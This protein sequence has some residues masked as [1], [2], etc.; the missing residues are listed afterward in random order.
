MKDA[1]IKI[2][3]AC[4]VEDE[5]YDVFYVEENEFTAE[6]F[7]Y[8][9]DRSRTDWFWIVDR[10][11]EFNGK[12]LYVPSEH[13]KEY[14]HVFKISGHLEFRY[15]KDFTD[16]WDFRCGGV[17]LVHKDFDYTKHKYQPKVIH[18]RYDI[19]YIDNPSNF[20]TILTIFTRLFN[21]ILMDFIWIFTIIEIRM[22]L[23]CPG[24]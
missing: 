19:F 3:P 11:F 9:A 13:E 2:H 24:H 15:P 14:I 20:E 16:P 8:Y 6:V 22:S 17:R 4:P 5:N 7:E 21:R 23:R 18:V 1:E 10:D 12:L